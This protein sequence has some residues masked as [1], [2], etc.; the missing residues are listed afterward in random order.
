MNSDF[1][2]S[3]EAELADWL[4][5][6]QAVFSANPTSFGGTAAMAATNG[7]LTTAFLN[8]YAVAQNEATRSPVAITIKNAA[9][10]EVIA[11]VRQ[12]GRLVQGTASVTPAMKQEL[13]LN[14][15]DTIPA[16]IPVPDSSPDIDIISV[17]GRVV[18]IRV[19]DASS[20]AKR[21]KPVG[22]YSASIY[23]FVGPTAPSDPSAYEFKG[24]ATRSI[25]EI[26]FPDSVVSGATV[27]LCAQWLNPRGQAGIACPPISVTLQG[28]AALP[29]AA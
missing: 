5:T 12:I 29:E 27:W 28:G 2:P 10:R 13:G 26:V 4:T 22:V 19:H 14:P 7:T 3:R 6:F 20:G 25:T 9:K 16:P 17:I 18:K 15:R 11:N 8:A 1:L 21:G 24:I 23:S